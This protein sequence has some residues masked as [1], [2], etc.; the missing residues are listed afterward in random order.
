[1]SIMPAMCTLSCKSCNKSFSTI[2]QNIW[3]LHYYGNV[4]KVFLNDKFAHCLLFYFNRVANQ[5]TLPGI[6]CITH[7][8]CSQLLGITY[9]ICFVKIHC[10]SLF[11]KFY[12]SQQNQYFKKKVWIQSQHMSFVKKNVVSQIKLSVIK[13]NGEAPLI[14]DPP[15]VNSKTMHIWQVCQDRNVCLVFEINKLLLLRLLTDP[16]PT[17]FTPR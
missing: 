10:N 17:S 15:S 14:A 9:R 7:L 16:L 8:V 1:M 5:K 4:Y 2:G 11:W 6:T 3:H 12:Y 13:L